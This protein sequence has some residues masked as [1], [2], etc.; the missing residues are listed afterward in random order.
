MKQELLCVQELS[1]HF[2]GLAALNNVSFSIFYFLSLIKSFLIYSLIFVFIN[3]F[4]FLM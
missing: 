3:D 2:G 4:F 1:R